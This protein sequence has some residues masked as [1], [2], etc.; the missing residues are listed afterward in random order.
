MLVTVA[1]LTKIPSLSANCFL[2]VRG[3]GSYTCMKRSRD[4]FAD[5]STRGTCKPR[6]VTAKEGDT[7]VSPLASY[8]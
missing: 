1:D 5:S 2:L 7:G 6:E 8:E 4:A 3:R